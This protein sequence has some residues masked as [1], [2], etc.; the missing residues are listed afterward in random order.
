MSDYYNIL[1]VQKNA[2]DSEIK[3][4]YRKLALKYHP[5]KNPDDSEAEKKFKE[6]S[7]AY[8][9]L[10]DD[11]KRR[12]YDQYGKSAFQGGMG[13]GAGAQGFPSMEEALRTFMGA[14]GGQGGG[15][16]G[17]DFF[18]NIFGGG[19]GGGMN[20]ADAPQKGTSK[21]VTVHITFNEAL[22]GVEKE[23]AITNYTNCKTCD[24]SGAKSPSDIKTCT[25]CGGHGQVHQS[26]GFFSMPTTC[27][28]C[29]GAGRI[30]TA[31]CPDCHG[32]GRIKTKEQVKVPIPAGIDSGMR[33]KMSGHGD[34]GVNGGPA[35]D[36][37]VYIEV[38]SHEFFVREGDDIIL[39]LPITFTEATL[40]IKKEIPTPLDGSYLLTI[41]EGSQPG[42]VLRVR[43]KGVPNVHGQGSGDL[44]I[45]LHIETPVHLNSEQKELLTK[46]QKLEGPQNSPKKKSFFE[47]VKSFF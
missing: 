44:L 25:T 9:I 38:K 45:Q 30:I 10:S 2:T 6:I 20:A 24:G 31:P 40:G 7:E 34:A 15:G 3:K 13:G 19:G 12:M 35:G 28:D 18:E 1:G 39:D 27:P 41:P 8:E 32:A 26:R 5:D 17:A 16:G 33:L 46:F 37:F 4:A 11:Q 21:R 23:L 22:K 47:K 14:F 43:G 42:K 29:H 36:L